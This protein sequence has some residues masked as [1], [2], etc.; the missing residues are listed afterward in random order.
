MKGTGASRRPSGA[1]GRPCA[2][3]DVS[4]APSKRKITIMENIFL[5]GSNEEAPFGAGCA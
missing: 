2:L 1:A 4:P 5:I 3:L